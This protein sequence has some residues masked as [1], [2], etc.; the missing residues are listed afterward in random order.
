[1][2]DK[3][4]IVVLIIIM[5]ITVVDIVTVADRFIIISRLQG[6]VSTFTTS[7]PRKITVI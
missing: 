4:N 3:R 5:V 1:M 2:I 7:Q 6:F